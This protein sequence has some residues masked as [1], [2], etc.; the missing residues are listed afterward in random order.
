MWMRSQASPDNAE[1]RED[2]AEVKH[3]QLRKS[4]LDSWEGIK[5]RN[6]RLEDLQRVE[7]ALQAAESVLQNLSGSEMHAELKPRGDL[8]TAA[9]RAV[10]E[11]LYEMLPRR[12]EGWLSEESADDARRLKK[13]RVWIVDPVDGTR[14]FLAGLP[15]W[16]ISIG[17]VEDREAVA[18][19]ICNPATGEMFL[20]SRETG[21]HFRLTPAMVPSPTKRSRPL[22]LASRREVERGEWDWLRNAPFEFRSLGSIAYKLAL[23][24]AGWAD[25]TWT[26]SPKHEWDIAAGVAL[27]LASGGKVR[28]LNGQELAFNQSETL[29]EGVIAFSAANEGDSAH[30]FDEWLSHYARARGVA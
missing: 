15:E 30:L 5:A 10:N 6:S 19:G 22:V 4:C 13:D 23:V 7:T 14:E 20:G 28:K 12:D 29:W 24:A 17:L 2:G 1:F 27:V 11:L 8:V 3:I 9:D 16:C 25:A 26:F 18:G 21:I